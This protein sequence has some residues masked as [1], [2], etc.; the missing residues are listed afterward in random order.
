VSLH[1]VS[2]IVQAFAST[3]G[4]LPGTMRAITTCQK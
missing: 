2:E 4:S 1:K 3:F